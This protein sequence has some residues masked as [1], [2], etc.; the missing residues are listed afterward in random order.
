MSKNQNP[1]EFCMLGLV[2]EKVYMNPIP[3]LPNGI[4]EMRNPSAFSSFIRNLFWTVLACVVFHGAI[5]AHAP[6]KRSPAGSVLIADKGKFKVLLDGKTIGHEEFEISPSGGGWT[7]KATTHLTP[8]GSPAATVTGNL[9]LQPDG[10]PIS[11]DWTSQADKNNAAHILFANNVAKMTIQLQGAHAFEQDLTFSSP[12]IV[13]LDD[14]LYYQYAVLARIYDWNRRGTQTFPVLVPQELLP[15]T[16]TV[17]WAGAVSADGKSY[18]GLKVVTSDLEV[19]LYLDSNHRLMRLEV[20]S[21]K[22][23]VIRE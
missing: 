8:E 9:S 20:P 4:R 10:V 6:Q 11:Y 1:E 5:F 18:E 16:I 13:V 22:A 23:A 7:A 2:S 12:L 19:I 3:V 14:N 21:S 15:N 17:D